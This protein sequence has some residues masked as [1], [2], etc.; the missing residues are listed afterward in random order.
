MTSY[1]PIMLNLSGKKVVIIGGGTVAARKILTLL[2]ANAEITVIS[3]ELHEKV[4]PA[5]DDHL[6]IWKQKCFEPAD[7]ANAFL[8]IAATNQE[9]VNLQVY[10]NT[11]NQQ[12][13]NV[14]DR[15]DLSSFIVPASFRRGKLAVAVSTS[16]A[17]PG[18]SRKIKQ[19]LAAQYDETYEDYINFLEQSRQRVLQEIADPNKRRK[20]LHSLLQPIFL[21]LT[22][23][24]KYAEREATF[25]ELLKKGD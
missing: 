12:L 24:T 20:I 16:G 25:T 10:E 7:L 3:P 22:Q 6:F 11:S 9:A 2:E 21:E 4:I 19:D 18:L 8:I 23:Q 17:M 1:Y 15:P 13:I 14:V 5:F